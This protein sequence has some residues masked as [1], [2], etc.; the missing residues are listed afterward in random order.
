[1]Q[2]KHFVYAEG[3][4]IAL[5]TQ[6]RDS[7][8]KLKNKQVRYLHYDALNSVDMISDGYGN[9]VERRSYDTWGKQRLISWRADSLAEVLQA[10]L[11]N[12]GYTGHE[13]IDEVGLIHMNGRV[14]DPEL[15]RFLSADPFIQ[16][17]YLTNSFNRYSYVMNNPVKYTD[18]TGYWWQ[19]GLEGECQ[20][21]GNNY[22]Y[23]NGT[24]HSWNS[25]H[26]G[27]ESGVRNGGQNDG[28]SLDTFVQQAN[29]W[30]LEVDKYIK[31]LPKY[32]DINPDRLVKMRIMGE[33]YHTGGYNH[34]LKALNINEAD[35]NSREISLA[36]AIGV[37]L[38]GVV[39]RG[40]GLSG[41]DVPKG[42]GP[43]KTVKGHHVHAK[44]AFKDHVS[45]SNKDGFS[46]SQKFMKENGLDH[47]AMTK[48]QR[49]AFKELNQSGRP[50]TLKEHT[51]I[52]V[53]ALMAGGA[54]RE[55]ARSLTAQS[56]NALRNSSVRT[57]TNI[58]WYK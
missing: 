38:K 56:L 13:H 50:N 22:N 19:G 45:Y 8:R 44:A 23:V 16:E 47:A 7:E 54:S 9:I 11:T 24:V 52:A 14:Y 39:G 37:A 15:G 27:S 26:N 43:Y 36:I 41:Y 57:P 3:K 21:D 42:T 28:E 40:K 10:K 12:R 6:I 20:T 46:I 35:T 2:H 51:T 53:D 55:T 31:Q 33:I 29:E 49:Q 30:L 17:P 25:S 1:M 32:F 5:N 58:P 48:Y 4:L 34:T 18:P